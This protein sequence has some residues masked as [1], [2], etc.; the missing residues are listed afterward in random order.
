MTNYERIFGTGPRG[1]LI[2][3]LL[4]AVCMFF[5][6]K[7]PQLNIMESDTL[8]Y[9]IFGMLSVV[10]LFVIIWSIKSLPLS[11]RGA[12][13]VTNGAFKYFRHPLYGAFLTFF[14]IG[15]AV[16]LNHWIYIIWA[17]A[18]HPLWHWNIKSE[19]KLMETAFPNEYIQYC[20]VT[21]RF[22]PR[23]FNNKK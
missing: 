23:L 10:A 16:L 5:E 1:T 3:L 14:N 9:S 13:L 6:N 20:K 19:E 7:I 11:D 4:L 15:L 22:V 18:L 2:S 17:I 12:S 8:R 21:G